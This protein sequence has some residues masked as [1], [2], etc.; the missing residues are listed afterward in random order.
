MGYYILLDIMVL[1]DYLVISNMRGII[2]L[3]GGHKICVR[4]IFKRKY[5]SRVGLIWTLM[6]DLIRA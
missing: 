1:S 5:R 3:V 4:P 6:L 2:F